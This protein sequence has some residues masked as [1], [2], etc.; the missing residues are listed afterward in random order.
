MV[1]EPRLQHQFR[2]EVLRDLDQALRIGLRRERER[3]R[4]H[5]LRPAGR[6][7]VALER[8]DAGAGHALGGQPVVQPGQVVRAEVHDV[9]ALVPR[10][11]DV[12]V[13][14]AALLR[15]GRVPPPQVGVRQDWHLLDAH[16]PAPGLRQGRASGPQAQESDASYAVSVEN[17]PA[18]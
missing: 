4:L 10:Q 14:R 16:E 5:H 17:G 1:H 15:R 7:H 11:R 9:H 8:L 12:Q 2:R 13:V 18:R 6:V 3:Q